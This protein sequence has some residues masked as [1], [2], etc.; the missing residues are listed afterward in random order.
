MF[1]WFGEVFAGSFMSSGR[2]DVGWYVGRAYAVI[3]STAVLI[4]LLSETI[5]LYARSARAA[6]N[7]RRER[8]R[9]MKEMEAVLIHLSRVTELGQSVSSVIHEVNQPLT[10]ISNYLAGCILLAPIS[11]MDKLTP[12]LERCQEQVVRA[13]GI[14]GRLR[15]F[16][17]RR[18]SEKVLN[19]VQEMLNSAIRLATVGIDAEAPAIQVQC[20]AAASKAFFDHIQIE[21][22]VFNLVRN[23][24]EAMGNSA[25]RVLTIRTTVNADDMVEVSVAD[26]GP[27]LAP[28]IR[29]RLFEPFVTSKAS[30][31]GIGLSICRAIIEAH[32]GRFSADDN[33]GGGTVFRFTLPRQSTTLA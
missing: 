4:I 9:R 28:D 31:R 8:E 33:P 17:A 3:S 2:F 13:T 24:I 18:D 16:I 1:A 32:G 6:A 29:S 25:R 26:T 30:G 19:N 14:V 7:E 27:G 12:L 5:S 10:A 23:A 20:E 15:D 21:Q 11:S 22:V